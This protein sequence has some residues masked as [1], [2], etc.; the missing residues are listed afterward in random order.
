VYQSLCI[1]ARR[2]RHFVN[3][4][5]LQNSL[6]ILAVS[7]LLAAT[8]F[9]EDFDFATQ[10]A[11]LFKQCVKCHGDTKQKGGLRFDTSAGAFQK[12]DSGL[13][14]IVPG[15]ADQSELIRR[16]TTSDTAERMPP[17]GE[18]L[19][20]QEIALLRRWIN[21]GASWPKDNQR[22]EKA[23]LRVTAEDRQHWSFRPLGSPS[24]PHL[25]SAAD[26]EVDAFVIQRLEQAGLKL[27]ERAPARTLA[28]RIY[29]DLIGLPPSPTQVE[30]F[31]AA[32][33]ANPKAAVASLVDRLLDSRH[34][35]ERWGRHWLDIARYADSNGQE[36]DQDRPFA[37]QY[38]DFVINA[39]NEDV[40]FDKFVQWQLAGDELDPN[41]P[42]AVA[43]TGFL[44]AGPHTVLNVPMEEEKTRNRY[45]ELDDMVSTI[46]SAMLGLTLACARCHDHK[47]DPI[48]TRDYYRMLSAVHTGD[49]ADAYLGA[50]SQVA[51][52]VE[53]GEQWKKQHDEVENRLNDWLKQQRVPFE[54]AL[55]ESKI[56]ELK[57]SDDDKAALRERLD[58]AQGRRLAKKHAKA[59]EILESDIEPLLKAEQRRELSELQ[60]QLA[61]INKSEPPAP[62]QALSFR[63]SVSQPKP[64]W[65]F[66]RADF[67]DRSEPVELGFLSVL[68]SSKGPAEYWQEARHAAARPD[69]TYQR[70]AIAR[71]ITDVDQG[72]GAL[73]ARVIVNRV[74]QHHF[75]AGLVRTPNDF[76]L[77][78]EAPSHPELLEGLARDLVNSGWQLKRLHRQIVLSSTYL[79]DS[80]YSP[81][82]AAV[83][84]ENRLLWRKSPRR[85]EAEIVRDAMLT[86]AGTINL[87]PFG[88]GF[89]PAIA[90]EAMVARNLKTPYR[91]DSDS[92]THRRSVY[93]FHKRVVPYPLLQ[94][95]DRPDALQSCGRRDNTTVAPQALALLNDQFVRDRAVEFAQR[96]EK[97]TGELEKIIPLAFQLAF[98]RSATTDEFNAS[99][100]FLNDRQKERQR[101][102]ANASATNARQHALAD[103][104]QSLFGLNEFIYVD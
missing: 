93:M 17:E 79:Q 11:P 84:P 44:V 52:Y 104:C 16:L 76:G 14:A 53:K 26:S 5:R 95:F 74:W 67:Y 8:S 72:A 78:G 81:A 97:Q 98:S 23:E 91:A 68:T 73:L 4:S 42:L 54:S 55:R 32:S 24:I 80:H 70:A 1:V 6:V 29:F 60:E 65:L 34:Y 99:L 87:S 13:A 102:E 66:H 46:G 9:G 40:P 3:N 10:I 35:G 27:S 18:S 89:K 61:V 12:G 7:M 101:R 96:L 59:L 21:S 38:R 48:P 43:A 47:Y 63:E 22:S 41:N 100:A 33:M 58:S 25:E 39:L 45:N 94:L 37:Y 82:K 2:T 83:D 28:R 103:F 71:W 77:Q 57:I 51:A 30:E 19:G 92:S 64:T 86:T 56:A 36:G 50:Q 49:R 20:G 15:D 75:G 88:P 31:E 69:S 62:E 90:A 85:L